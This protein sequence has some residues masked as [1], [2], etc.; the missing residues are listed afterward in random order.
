MAPYMEII[1]VSHR[2]YACLQYVTFWYIIDNLADPHHRD[3][4]TERDE[5]LDW[6]MTTN[7]DSD[8]DDSEVVVDQTK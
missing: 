8:S 3:L 5:E 2:K 4:G 1:L 7:E 6:E